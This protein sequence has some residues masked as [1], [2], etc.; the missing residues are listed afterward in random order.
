MN[1]SLAPNVSSSAVGMS[2]LHY[3]QFGR[4]AQLGSI[5]VLVLAGVQPCVSSEDLQTVQD[6]GSSSYGACLMQGNANAVGKGLHQD[7][8]DDLTSA[9]NISYVLETKVPSLKVAGSINHH[10]ALLEQGIGLAATYAKDVH[11]ALLQKLESLSGKSTAAPML[12]GS[13]LLFALLVAVVLAVFGAKDIDEGQPFHISSRVDSATSHIRKA[14]ELF[15]SDDF[16]PPKSSAPPSAR[17]LPVLDA[18]MKRSLGQIG[19]ATTD[20]DGVAEFKGQHL[21]RELVVPEESECSLLVPRLPFEQNANSQAS[22]RSPNSQ[23]LEKSNAMD[24]ELTID[25]SRG[26]P[27]FRMT[28]VE[29]NKD[30][31]KHLCLSSA[32]GER[33]LFGYLA[34]PVPAQDGPPSFLKIHHHSGALFGTLRKEN[35]DRFRV[36][37][38]PGWELLF[39]GDWETGALNVTDENGGLQA[40]VEPLCMQN[41]PR[42]SVR[43]GPHVDAGLVVLA[44]LGIDLLQYRATPQAMGRKSSFSM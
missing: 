12:I 38:S 25:D 43:I 30:S 29:P 1:R 32:I 35:G 37:A 33:I 40:I 44:L 8:E 15:G 18:S 41:V 19:H 9:N 20:E 3:S 21:C 4:R 11:I 31:G 22:M 5:A 36:R 6:A 2:A 10:P 42:C 7:E 23:R 28:T 27:V 34:E 14:P 24:I 26:I 13:A 17:L 16:F 39:T